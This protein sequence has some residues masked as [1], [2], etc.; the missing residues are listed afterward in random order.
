M[1]I[2]NRVAN[3]IKMVYCS[4]ERVDGGVCTR[5]KRISAHV[6]KILLFRIC[7]FIYSLFYRD[8]LKSNFSSLH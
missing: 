6:A 3:K 7:L 2:K 4:L 1:A 5:V 8:M